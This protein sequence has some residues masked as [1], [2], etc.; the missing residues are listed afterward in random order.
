M[1]DIVFKIGQ[2]HE[3]MKGAYKVLAVNRDTICICWESGEEVTTTAALQNRIIERMDRERALMR[4]KKSEK[5]K[6]PQPPELVRKFEGLKEDDFT[7][8]IAG[9]TWRYYDGLGGAVA[10]RLNSDR[11]D[12]TSWPRYGLSEV[13]WAD[14][15]H[16]HHSDFRLQA[17]F[18]ARLDENR[19]YVGL[20]IGR[21]NEEK[22]AKDDWNAFMAWLRDAENE[23]WLHKL[24]SEQDLSI[25]DIKGEGA[26]TGTI[27]SGGEK[28]RWSNE[29]QEQEIESLAGF[30]DGLT[31]SA[32]VDLQIAKIVDKDEVVTR[33]V[34]IAYDIARLFEMLMPLYEASAVCG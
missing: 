1:T 28:W 17:K 22:D 13:H 21:S 5:R 4:A 29:D 18:F 26:F 33:D 19:L 27:V 31:D 16:R 6:R 2:E 15:S 23:F 30:L 32:W 10:V 14:L 34:E 7:E 3:N 11:F 9:A 25:Y 8:D 24:V 12:I 20:D